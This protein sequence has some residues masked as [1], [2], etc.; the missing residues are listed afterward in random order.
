MAQDLVFKVK[1]VK[2]KR[3]ILKLRGIWGG[4][5]GGGLASQLPEEKYIRPCHTFH[6]QAPSWK[7]TPSPTRI[8][9]GQ[10]VSHAVATCGRHAG[11][12]S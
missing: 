1:Q 7:T 3:M 2:L 8:P 9:Q 4:S 12:A 11:H 10:T 5:G 6:K